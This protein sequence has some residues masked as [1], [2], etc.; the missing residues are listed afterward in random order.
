[1]RSKLAVALTALLL[2]PAACRSA[3]S[4][5]ADAPTHGDEVSRTLVDYDLVYNDTIGKVG[6]LKTYRVQHAGESPKHFRYVFDLDFEELGFFDR[7]GNAWVY[8][9]YSPF[10]TEIHG[11][12]MRTRKM[13]D[14]LVGRN[15]M[16]M[17]GLDPNVGSVTFPQAQEGD[18]LSADSD[19]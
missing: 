16:R 17:L 2:V 10:E 5:V 4:T 14:D 1:M 18:I 13:Q 8:D 6:Y 12:P 9:R 19:G 3:D 15:A 7:F 11:T